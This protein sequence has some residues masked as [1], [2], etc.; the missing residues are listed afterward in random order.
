MT[1]KTFG[2]GRPTSIHVAFRIVWAE[3]AKL[4]RYEDETDRA[5][6]LRFGTR[7]DQPGRDGRTRLERWRP[8]CQLVP[9]RRKGATRAVTTRVAAATTRLRR[10]RHKARTTPDA[11]RTTATARTT[12][13]TTRVT[14]PRARTTRVADRTMATDRTTTPA[15]RTTAAATADIRIGGKNYK[16]WYGRP[17][18]YYPRPYY[19]RP[20]YPYYGYR[21]VGYPGYY[22]GATVLL[23]TS[24]Q[25]QQQFRLAG[26]SRRRR[27]TRFGADERVPQFAGAT[28]CACQS[29]D[30]GSSRTPPAARFE[31][32]LLRT[33]DRRLRQRVAHRTASSQ[34]NW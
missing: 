6:S 9:W 31:R 26:V 23:R 21:P 33:Y 22:Y 28:G 16:G 8:R 3:C 30:C 25:Q 14:S 11:G 18:Y 2:T 13:T 27:D 15:I 24:P 1:V 19:A 34:C 20:Y 5:R 12:A 10:P 7:R 32:Q 4:R 29:G 17:G